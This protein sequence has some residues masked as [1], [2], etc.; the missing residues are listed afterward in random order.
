[1]AD[2]EVLDD[3]LFQAIGEIIESAI[4]QDAVQLPPTATTS[5]S[6]VKLEEV[7]RCDPLESSI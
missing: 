6:L 5:A 4:G 7:I 2:P 1:M 3:E